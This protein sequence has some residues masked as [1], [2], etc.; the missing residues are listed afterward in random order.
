MIIAFVFL[1]PQAGDEQRQAAPCPPELPTDSRNVP[2]HHTNRQT[3]ESEGHQLDFVW[4]SRSIAERVR[5][6]AMNGVAEWGPS[7]HCRVEIL[8]DP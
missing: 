8:I 2:T 5:A 6:R 7:D 3:P 1:G 4:A